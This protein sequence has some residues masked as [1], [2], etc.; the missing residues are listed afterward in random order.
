MDEFPLSNKHH[1]TGAGEKHWA[2]TSPVFFLMYCSPSQI[3]TLLTTLLSRAIK[4]VA[5][6]QNCGDRFLKKL[7]LG[8][9]WHEFFIFA[10]LC[11]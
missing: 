9:I 4:I 2:H 10:K 3:S 7:K 11:N 8:K 6:R 1:E 5:G